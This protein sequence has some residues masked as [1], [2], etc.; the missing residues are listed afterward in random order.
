MEIYILRHGIAEDRSPGGKDSERALTDKGRKKTRRLA[1]LLKEL[2]VDFDVIL[3]SPL[4]RARQ[5]AEELAAKM[6]LKDKITCS[7]NLKPG[8][9][10]EALLAEL[11]ETSMKSGSVLL[12]GHEPDLS[13]LISRLLIGKP[14]LDVEMKK[15]G[16]CK[17]EVRDLAS[18][19]GATLQWL[20]PPAVADA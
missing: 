4:V 7:E 14:G 20:I 3:T 1:A 12:V 18:R 13:G 9:D 19:S 5:T 6:K 11:Q 16:L 2:E 17:L 8:F 10:Y 15:G